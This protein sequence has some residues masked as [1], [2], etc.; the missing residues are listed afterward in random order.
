MNFLCVPPFPGIVQEDFVTVESYPL[1]AGTFAEPGVFTLGL[2]ISVQ[3]LQLCAWSIPS[4]SCLESWLRV[5][6]LS[7]KFSWHL[8]SLLSM[9]GKHA[10][11]FT[12]IT[13]GFCIMDFPALPER[14]DALSDPDLQSFRV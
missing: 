12:C 6:E 1:I 5:L 9:S 14:H 2:V 8:R 10:L 4:L 13:V 3:S 7:S 11:F